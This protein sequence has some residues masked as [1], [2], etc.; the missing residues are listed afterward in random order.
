MLVSHLHAFVYTKTIKTGSTSVEAYFERFTTTAPDW[1]FEPVRPPREDAEGIVGFRGGAVPERCRFWHHM[2]AREIRRLI[3]P[4]A[5]GRYTK[6]CVVRNP[7]ERAVSGFF[8][9]ERQRAD[10]MR[11]A[12][13]AELRAWFER[14]TFEH[15]DLLR[16]DDKYLIDGRMCM[17]LVLRHECLPADLEALCGR[18]GLPWDP[19]GLPGFKRGIR[20]PKASAGWLFTPAARARVAE[21]FAADLDRFGYGFPAG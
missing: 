17:D 12:G 13:E 8:F 5:W 20:P 10:A 21:V 9:F 3:G 19:Q 15:L 16:D 18:L 14:W 6:F 7:F 11:R 1:V 2:P 4:E